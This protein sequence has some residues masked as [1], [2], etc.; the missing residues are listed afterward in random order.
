LGES[1]MQRSDPHGRPD[2]I[3]QVASAAAVL[4]LLPAIL[5]T[6]MAYAYYINLRWAILIASVICAVLLRANKGVLAVCIVLGLLFN[7]F[8]PFHTTR[9]TWRLLDVVA[10]AGFVWIIIGPSRKA[11]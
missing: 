7:P 1:A 10:V 5:D 3:S 11:S 6:R 9:N 8:K 2:R 4:F